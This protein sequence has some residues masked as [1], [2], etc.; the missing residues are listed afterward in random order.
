MLT[1]SKYLKRQLVELSFFF[2]IPLKAI[3]TSYFVHSLEKAMKNIESY[4]YIVE[5][6]QTSTI[7]ATVLTHSVMNP[8][9]PKDLCW[10]GSSYGFKLLYSIAESMKKEPAKRS[11]FL[12]LLLFISKC[13]W[14]TAQLHLTAQEE[15]TGGTIQ[16][17]STYPVHSW[18]GL[19][20]KKTA[21]LNWLCDLWETANTQLFTS[22]MLLL[23]YF[24]LN[25]SVNYWKHNE[26][27]LFLV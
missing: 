15:N 8:T 11:H 24:T 16:I 6:F 2:T 4:I 13:H 23:S 18:R 22:Q 20:F 14:S 17:H 7:I 27:V 21:K 9:V 10:E 19:G 5:V 25:R 26:N 3:S 12:P 1:E